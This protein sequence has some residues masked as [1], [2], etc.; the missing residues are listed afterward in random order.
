M[1]PP[2]P[3]PPPLFP[4]S[5]RQDKAA[6]RIHERLGV[7]PWDIFHRIS[8]PDPASPVAPRPELYP[9]AEA[10][11]SI[12]TLENLSSLA[13]R[14]ESNRATPPSRTPQV[15]ADEKS[16]LAA[17]ISEVLIDAVDTRVNK[18]TKT[19]G[20][21]ATAVTQPPK[22]PFLTCQDIK[23]VL[24]KHSKDEAKRQGTS[25]STTQQ[26]EEEEED[27]DEEDV[28]EEDAEQHENSALMNLATEAART[29]PLDSTAGSFSM[30]DSNTNF[31]ASTG[32]GIHNRA[33]SFPP[34]MQRFPLHESHSRDNHLPSRR[35]RS[36]QSF[37]STLSPSPSI[38][39]KRPRL[40][41]PRSE[42]S[43]PRGG[44]GGDSHV[45]IEVTNARHM[46]SY[47]ENAELDSQSQLS[48]QLEDPQLSLDK[49]ELSAVAEA[50]AAVCKQSDRFDKMEAEL[51]A[52]IATQKERN[53]TLEKTKHQAEQAL[54]EATSQLRTLEENCD[55]ARA[56]ARQ[57]QDA[58]AK[59][60]GCMDGITEASVANSLKKAID[61][62]ETSTVSKQAEADAMDA[63][64]TSAKHQIA[65]CHAKLAAAVEGY[66]EGLERTEAL[67][68]RHKAT[69]DK[70]KQWGLVASTIRVGPSN[71]WHILFQYP[72]V[73]ERL[74]DT[75]KQLRLRGMSIDERSDG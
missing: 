54:E 36:S 47:H 12:Q 52:E 62:Q 6:K 63:N 5:G 56:A 69:T 45:D 72:D 68:G 26:D 7:W 66:N 20:K 24:A 8:S 55:T 64:L 25:R 15:R 31:I 35:R 19:T 73:T 17:R 14:L 51:E 11:W 67:M 61:E 22:R 27:E 39:N 53:A 44:L 13:E 9:P 42:H 18:Q 34:S 58:L 74:Q 75:E 41:R 71:L 23:T 70:K 50:T 65:Q 37:P 40:D 38:S 59:L 3:T 10:G 21:G 33:T 60:Q 49:D 16:A 32:S 30:D 28:Q 46:D 43:F 2:S 29:A 4:P 48:F 57:A 1:A